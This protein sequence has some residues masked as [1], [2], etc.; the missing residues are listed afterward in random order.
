MMVRM[1]NQIPF[2]LELMV[3]QIRRALCSYFKKLILFAGNHYE[4]SLFAGAADAV[5]AYSSR[6]SRGRSWL[7]WRAYIRVDD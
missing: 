1:H 4:A 2:G 6:I 7:I 3:V 5:T